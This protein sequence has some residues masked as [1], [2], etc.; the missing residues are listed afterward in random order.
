MDPATLAILTA[1]LDDLT[2]FLI[3]LVVVGGLFWLIGL[4]IKSRTARRLSSADVALIEKIAEIADR[5]DRRMA[6]VEQILEHDAPA[7]RRDNATMGGD[8]GRKVG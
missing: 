5:M 1:H 3:V 8:Y 6:A 4:F 2:N 7:W